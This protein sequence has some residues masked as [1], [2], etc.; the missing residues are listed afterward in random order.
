MS[1]LG[2]EGGNE[3]GEGGGD[4]DGC[5]AEGARVTAMPEEHEDMPRGARRGEQ[6][7]GMVQVWAHI[8]I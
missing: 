2:G 3:G 6:E 8:Y 7:G 5:G 4:G 1:Q